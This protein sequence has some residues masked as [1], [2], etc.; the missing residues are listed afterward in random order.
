MTN[1]NDQLWAIYRGIVDQGYLEDR[2][3]YQAG[4]LGKMYDLDKDGSTKLYLMIQSDQNLDYRW[5]SKRPELLAEMI[6]EAVHEG[7][8][9]W[10]DGDRVVIQSFLSDIAHACT[11]GYVDAGM[12]SSPPKYFCPCCGSN[13]TRVAGIDQ[14]TG[15]IGD[16]PIDPWSRIHLECMNCSDPIVIAVEV[17]NEVRDRRDTEI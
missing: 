12:P 16:D 1:T 5:S 15:S 6:D 10:E 3:E 8:D 11:L 7:F 13:Q 17:V 9:G 4:D 14:V 2:A